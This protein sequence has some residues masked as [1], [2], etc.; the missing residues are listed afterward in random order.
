MASGVR[1]ALKSRLEEKYS[2]LV[3]DHSQLEIRVMGLL[4]RDPE[5]TRILQDPDG[6]IHSESA[7][8]FM[9]NRDSAKSLNFLMLYG[10]REYM[11]AESLTQAGNPVTPQQC[12]AFQVI[13]NQT[14]ARV[15]EYRKE[16]VQHHEQHGY[17]VLLTG[18]TRTLEDPDYNSPYG[19]HSI[20]TTLANNVVQG[21]G[22][23]FLKAAIVRLDPY[24][25]NPDSAALSLGLG[26][27]RHKEV[28]RYHS[29]RLAKIRKTLLKAQCRYLL[30]VHDELIFGVLREAEEECL[31]LCAEVM[32]W[33]HY[34]P[35][36]FDQK[37]EPYSIP[38]VAE[39]G[40]ALN[41]KDAKSK[42]KFHCHT[43]YGFQYWNK[44]RN[45]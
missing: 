28:L 32:V 5:I 10:G 9:V 16:L 31:E 1:L 43:K 11:M 17:V 29:N 19:R 26:S 44:I 25:L 38:L 15:P 7:S 12:A 36:L 8:R 42:D 2:L 33:E 30:Q 45:L 18:R 37:A 13:Y 35:S 4:C 23:D 3:L 27:L 39:G 34:I 24:C 40:A 41:W 21:T 22:Q 14:Y 6:D 20:E